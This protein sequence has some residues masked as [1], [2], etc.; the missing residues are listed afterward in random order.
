MSGNRGTKHDNNI[1]RN[2]RGDSYFPLGSF[3][4]DVSPMGAAEPTKF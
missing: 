4:R 1:R 3:T 2:V